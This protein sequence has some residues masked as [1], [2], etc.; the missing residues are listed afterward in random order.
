MMLIVLLVQSHLVVGGYR[1]HR[2]YNYNEQSDNN[3]NGSRRTKNSVTSPA[4]GAFVFRDCGKQ[5]LAR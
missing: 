5:A 2:Y 1:H 3:E 4:S